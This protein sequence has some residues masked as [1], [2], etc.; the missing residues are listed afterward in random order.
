M[1]KQEIHIP[2]VTLRPRPDGS[3]RPRYIPG[4]SHRALGFKGQN[5]RHPDGSWFGLDDCL[6]WSKVRQ[7]EIAARSREQRDQLERATT[8]RARSYLT[9]ADLFDRWF[10]SPLMTGKA[11]IEGRLERQPAAPTTVAFY[12]SQ[13]RRIEELD[14]GLVWQSP[15][16]L[17]TARLVGNRKQGILRSIEVAHGL[18]TA[19]GV[20][21]ALSGAYEF[22]IGEGL[23]EHNPTRATGYKLPVP[24][25]RIRVA[26][27]E[28]IRQLVAAADAIGLPEIGDSVVLGVW[29]GQR[30]SDR[31]ALTDAQYRPGE[32][33]L[34]RQRKKGGQPLQIPDAPELAE[35]L[36]AARKRRAGWRVN[37]T[38]VLLDEEFRRPFERRRRY[39]DLF[40]R[41]REAAVRGVLTDGTLGPEPVAGRPAHVPAGNLGWLVAPLPALAGLHDQ[42][43]RDTAVTWLARAGCTIPEIAGVTG[44]SLQTIHDVL[45]HYLGLHPELARTAIGKLVEWHTAHMGENNG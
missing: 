42:D 4:K 2:L 35:R 29:S 28:E 23:V 10:K 40:A 37:Y 9:V 20:K 11:T 38:H 26:E 18:H 41:A 31:L 19:R 1:G 32:G 8:R 15:A 36:A 39:H 12:K 6:A 22:G 34:F 21:A 7:E 43:L 24:A 3:F 25:P 30:Q 33:Y 16:T 44:H 13:S 5:L 14:G 45:K 17:L 27:P